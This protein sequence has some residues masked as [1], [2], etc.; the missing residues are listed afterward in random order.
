MNHNI[1]FHRTEVTNITGMK[2]KKVKKTDRYT[3]WIR[4]T[5]NSKSFT[6]I[7]SSTNRT[8]ILH[9]LLLVETS[10]RFYYNFFVCYM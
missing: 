1:F 2:T 9:N 6:L 7:I 8:V 5:K 3:E 10:G 4:K